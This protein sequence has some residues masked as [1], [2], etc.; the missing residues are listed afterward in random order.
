MRHYLST[1][2]F[3]ASLLLMGSISSVNANGTNSSELDQIRKKGIVTSRLDQRSYADVVKGV[4]KKIQSKLNAISPDNIK[5]TVRKMSGNKTGN[6]ELNYMPVPVEEYCVIERVN[7]LESTTPVNDMLS[8]MCDSKFNKDENKKV[9]EENKKLKI[10][11]ASLKKELDSL[12]VSSKISLKSNATSGAPLAPPPPPLPNTNSAS[13]PPPPPLP[14]MLGVPAPP[15]LPG[16]PAAPG[17]GAP[18]LNYAQKRVV[19][20]ENKKSSASYLMEES[21]PSAFKNERDLFHKLRGKF[22]ELAGKDNLPDEL[23]YKNEIAKDSEL[24]K[25]FRH[26]SA[27]ELFNIYKLYGDNFR[28]GLEKMYPIKVGSGIDAEV[29]KENQDFINKGAVK[30]EDKVKQLRGIA[31]SIN[32]DDMKKAEANI[33]KNKDSWLKFMNSTKSSNLKEIESVIKEREANKQLN[34]SQ[35]ELRSKFAVNKNESAG[36]NVGSTNGAS[37]GKSFSRAAID[38]D[39]IKN[40]AK[41]FNNSRKMESFNKLGTGSKVKKSEGN[42]FEKALRKKFKNQPSMQDESNDADDNDEWND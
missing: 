31:S 37:S 14:G 8:V 35:E 9:F 18:K 36:T 23:K 11:I 42:F 4:Q 39:E 15:P 41:R 6:K 26:Y 16:A 27:A 32:N 17:F 10:E 33:S 28:S 2:A 12:K 34:L 30:V 1:K 29:A 25:R 19:D 40:F 7:K 3:L 38:P 13:V 5:R 21:I 20:F 24:K 22:I